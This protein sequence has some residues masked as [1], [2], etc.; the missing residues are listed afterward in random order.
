[1]ANQ[2]LLDRDRVALAGVLIGLALVLAGM[3]Y[4]VWSLTDALAD[5]DAAVRAACEQYAAPLDLSGMAALCSDAGYQQTTR[6]APPT[7]PEDIDRPTQ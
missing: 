3:G 6:F 7:T 1:M 5:R 4:W 2:T